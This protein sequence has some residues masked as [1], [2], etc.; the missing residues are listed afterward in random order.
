MNKILSGKIVVIG[1]G[2]IG[3]ALV[4]GLQLTAQDVEIFVCDRGELNP[5][6]GYPEGLDFNKLNY[7]N[8]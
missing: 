2:N 6:E 4:R 5:N 7:L 8:Y 3:K 1:F